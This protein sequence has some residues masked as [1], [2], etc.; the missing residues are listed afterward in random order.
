MYARY[1][2]TYG[3]KANESWL[4]FSK[5]LILVKEIT[6]IIVINVAR[7]LAFNRDKV[8]EDPLKLIVTLA[9]YSIQEH[10]MSERIKQGHSN[11]YSIQAAKY[12]SAI[13]EDCLKYLLQFQ[14]PILKHIL[15]DFALASYT[16]KFWSSHFRKMKDETGRV[17]QVAMSLMSKEQPAYLTWIRLYDPDQPW[18]FLRLDR[19]LESTAMPLYYAAL[20]GLCTITEK[21]LDEGADINAAGKYDNVLS[22]ASSYGY[23]QVVKILLDAGANVNA[24]DKYYGNALRAATLE[25]HEQ[26]AKLLVDAGAVFPSLP[27]KLL[28]Q[29]TR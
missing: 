9:H 7:K 16:A 6:K 15:K 17:N 3:A 19:G 29:T 10:L 24:P 13:A 5:Q 25:R 27:G 21:L 4:T 18:A 14:Q 20:L 23:E 12:H 22:A 28:W 1:L 11:Q 26:V 8:L 2:A